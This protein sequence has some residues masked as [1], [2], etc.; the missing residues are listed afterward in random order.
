MIAA[1]NTLFGLSFQELTAIAEQ[2]GQ[3]SYRA[4]QLYQAMYSQRQRSLA[5]ITNLPG[6][7]KIA[8]EEH[9]FSIELPKLH[10]QFTSGDGTIRYL[11]E[12]NDGHSVKPLWMLEAGGGEA[13]GGRETGV[14]RSR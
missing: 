6:D 13:A 1:R 4:R 8:L 10:K 11:L 12:L 7:F 9:G 2:F 14:S 3:P 5:E